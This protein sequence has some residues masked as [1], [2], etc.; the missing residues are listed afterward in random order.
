MTDEQLRE[1]MESG[2]FWITHCIVQGS[3][4]DAAK[5]QA[6]RKMG[7]THIF[8]V[9]RTPSC[10]QAG[11]SGFKEIVDLPIDD[12]KQL[13]HEFVLGFLYQFHRAAMRPDSICYIHCIAGQNR[14]PTLL[15]LYFVACGLS[16][17]AARELIEDRTLDAV[18]GHPSLVDE[19]LIRRVQYYGKS[20]FFP[21][22]R[23]DVLTPA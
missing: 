19:A 14:S 20:I 17:E 11:S 16:V 8:N 15:W 9:G 4:P 21:L 7:V 10:I 1:S 18:A 13:Q 2:I 22:A 6:L 5:L 3:Y 23:P 12:L